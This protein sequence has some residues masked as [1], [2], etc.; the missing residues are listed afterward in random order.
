MLNDYNPDGVEQNGD[1]FNPIRAMSFSE[2][3]RDSINPER[4]TAISVGCKPYV[5]KTVRNIF[6]PERV[7]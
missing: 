5:Y 7:A 6:S 4:V 2:A 1:G 3:N